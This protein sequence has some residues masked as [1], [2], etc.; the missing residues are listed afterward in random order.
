MCPGE[1]KMFELRRI[2]ILKRASAWLLDVILLA[3]LATGFMW[4]ISLMCNYSAEE[5][6]A[7]EY[8]AE[9][10]DFRKEYVPKIAERYGYIY[11]ENGDSYTLTKDGKTVALS[12]LI[13]E[14]SET[15]DKDD[16]M[17][18]AYEAYCSLTPAEKVN[19]QYRYV[20]TLLFMLVSIG[21]LLG[22]IVLE[23]I[24]P[25]ILKN[26]QTV[27]KKVFA[28]CVVRPDC[29]KI[30]GIAL[31]ARTLLGKYAVETMFPVLLVFLF[32]FGG[33]GILAIILFAALLLLNTILFF[34]TKNRTP[35]HDLIAGTATAD[36]KLQIIYSSEE[37]L[38]EK[39]ALLRKAE[40]EN[41]KEQQ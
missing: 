32:F 1:I 16:A 30:T 14:L 3:V 37:E 2:G 36:M 38:N 31:F 7:N 13:F 17:Q 5:K 23:F 39:K 25:L 26:G 9:W 10:E 21:I 12:D 40:V 18:T 33:L 29:V 41:A 24:I 34:A 8:Y 11:S 19:A 28:I 6:L 27:G 22:Y 4:I 20:Y 35:I 15:K